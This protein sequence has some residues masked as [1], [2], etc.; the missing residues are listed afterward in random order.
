L[1]R[2]FIGLGLRNEELL[3]S[4]EQLK[5]QLDDVLK[6]LNAVKQEREEKAARQEK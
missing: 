3:K 1:Q 2:G 5:Q 6:E 4:N